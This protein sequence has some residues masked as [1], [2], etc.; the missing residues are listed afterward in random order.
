LPL[1]EPRARLTNALRQFVGALLVQLRCALEPLRR[2]L[3]LGWQTLHNCL[4]SAPAP[5][6]MTPDEQLRH[7][8]LD[9]VFFCEPRRYMTVLSTAGGM[10]LGLAEGRGAR[11]ARQLLEALPA[12]SRDQVA[13]VASDFN[14]GQIQAAQTCLPLALVCADCFHLVRLGRRMLR[15]CSVAQQV[16]ARRAFRELRRVLAEGPVAALGR[17]LQR[18]QGQPGPLGT[19]YTT[20]DRWQVEIENYLQTGRTTGPAEALNRKI[21]LLRRTACGY[22][23]RNNFVQRILLLNH[24]PHHQQ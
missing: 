2:W 10:V 6:L 8:C 4:P 17:W 13:T 7:L 5:L 22:T 19:F 18:W 15:Q 21:A 24:S 14:A 3:G 16:R 20:V 12:S 9:E 1:A 23:N 11:P